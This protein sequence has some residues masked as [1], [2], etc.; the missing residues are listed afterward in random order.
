MTVAAEVV[1]VTVPDGLSPEVAKAIERQLSKMPPQVA[2]RSEGQGDRP[3]PDPAPPAGFRPGDAVE[4]PGEDELRALLPTHDDAIRALSQALQALGACSERVRVLEERLARI[5]Q[6]TFGYKCERL[7]RLGLYDAIGAAGDADDR[8]GTDCHADAG[9]RDAPC[10]HGTADDADP[11]ATAADAADAGG[12]D[13]RVHDASGDGAPDGGG[14]EAAWPPRRAK[15]GKPRRSKG[16]SD[17]VAGNAVE[18]TVRKRVDEATLEAIRARGQTPVRRD[19]GCYE[20]V[21]LVSL[22]VL[23]RTVYEVWEVEETGERLAAD[24]AADSKPMEN[25]PLGADTLAELLFLR[26]AV[27]LPATRVAREAVVAGLG[28]TKQTVYRVSTQLALSLA[29]LV[30]ARYL[31]HV[32]LAGCVQSDET[33][34][35]VRQELVEDGRSNSVMWLVRTSEND[36][37]AHQAVVLAHTSTRSAEALAKLIRGFEGKL[38]ADGYPGYPRAVRLVAEALAGEDPGEESLPIVLAG[39]LQHCRSKFFDAVQALVGCGEWRALDESRRR[40]LPAVSMLESISRVFEAERGMPRDAPREA[41]AEYRRR[42]VRPLLKKVLLKCRRYLARGLGELD[43]YLG[44]ALRYTWE[45]ATLLFAAVDDPD[46]PLHNSACEREFANFGVIRNASRQVDSSMG[47]WTLAQW[48]SVVRTARLNGADERVY[49]E[50]LIER[51]IPLL[52]EHGDWQW[53]KVPREGG[54]KALDVDGLPVPEDTGYLDELMPW[55]DEYRAYEASWRDRRRDRLLTWARLMGE[56]LGTRE[57]G[58][59]A[60]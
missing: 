46:V 28:V 26:Y 31:E 39:C 23:V 11:G 2:E 50:Y 52:R 51:G 27:S 57:A 19:D 18:V 25:S 3:P 33:W 32:L 7:E 47:A 60:A 37:G 38:M 40:A 44:R 14:A 24:R 55:S 12:D 30:V 35:G 22:A 29:R 34:L 42:R 36:P 43:D 4:V 49:L 16:C 54:W 10:D 15:E 56:Q 20:T 53:H 13:P 8:G 58:S 59:G 45:Q 48:F 9:G 5:R 1:S 6:V 21:H 17:H 41:R